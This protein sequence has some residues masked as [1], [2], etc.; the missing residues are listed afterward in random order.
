MLW[1]G[2]V[3]VMGLCPLLGRDEYPAGGDDDRVLHDRAPDHV[4]V[5]RP[6]VARP[7]DITAPRSETSDRGA[8]PS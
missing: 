6:A 2:G 1:N 8:R 3:R 4:L 5:V 7:R